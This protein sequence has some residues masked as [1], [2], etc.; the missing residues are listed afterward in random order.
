MKTRNL[1]LAIVGGYLFAVLLLLGGWW[2]GYDDAQK[3]VQKAPALP[4][5]STE[6]STN[7]VWDA[8]IHGNGEGRSFVD[9]NGRTY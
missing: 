4:M 7:C 9:L 1:I 3:E 8:R 6:D 2:I 5:C